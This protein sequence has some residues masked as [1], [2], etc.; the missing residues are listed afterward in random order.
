MLNI[1]DSNIGMLIKTKYIKLNY[2]FKH[3]LKNNL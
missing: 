2:V 1:D 3:C